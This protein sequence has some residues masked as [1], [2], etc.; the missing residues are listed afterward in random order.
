[1]ELNLNGLNLSGMLEGAKNSNSISSQIILNN[2]N[3]DGINL[4]AVDC[5]SSTNTVL[6]ELASVGV[7]DKTVLIADCQT[8][9]RGRLGKSFFSPNGTG[10]YMSVLVRAPMCADK[11][12]MVTPLIAVAVMNVISRFAQNVKIKWVNDIYIGDKKVC[13]I[14]TESAFNDMNTTD[15]IVIGLGLNVFP[16]DKNF[17]AEFAARA[18]SLFSN[19]E[20]CDIEKLTAMIIDSIFAHLTDFDTEYIVSAYTQNSWL[21]GKSVNV[22]TVTDCYSAKVLGID[23]KLRL[24][25]EKDSGE[26]VHLSSADVSTACD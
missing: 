23:E 11:A 22:S 18:T 24:I 17:P 26:V 7:P 8:G 20:D 4:I 3:T 10:L 13:G 19:K 2:L 9:G 6:K 15:Y 14:L 16:P 21:D 12:L 1:M 25:V 5:L